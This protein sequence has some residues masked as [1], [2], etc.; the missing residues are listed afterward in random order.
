MKNHIKLFIVLLFF[1]FGTIAQAFS[2]GPVPGRTG[3]PGEATCVDCHDEYDLNSGSGN[4][5][6]LDLPKIYSPGQR[7]K[8]RVNVTQSRQSRWGFQITALDKN[9]QFAGQ[10]AI[11]DA[12][13]TQIISD[14]GRSYVEHTTAGTM[15]TLKDGNDWSFDWI[16]PSTDIGPV[17]FFVAGNAANGSTDPLGDYIYTNV[18]QIGA[19]SDAVVTLNSPNGGEVLQAG[20][21]YTIRWNSTNALG[22][23]ILLQPQGFGDV[24]TTIVTGLSGSAKEYQWTVPNIETSK[25]RIIVVA[26][27]QQGRADS[28]TSDTGFTIKSGTQI[29]GP[30]ISSIMVSNKR[31]KFSGSGFTSSTKVFIN[32]VAFV[33]PIALQSMNTILIQK[34]TTTDGRTIGQLI[35]HGTQV[36][37]KLLNA[38]GGITEMNYLRP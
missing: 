16:A 23:Y 2:S 25:A 20:S 3:A 10:F 17:T 13:R 26:E 6:I 18:A 8:V 30:N 14:K 35:P 4:V 11:T 22:H 36:H 31:I 1:V 27:G 15:S 28:D 37:I 12:T 5:S 19:P 7:I 33:K 29:P 9:E 38:D 24:P 32:D 21:S 34:G